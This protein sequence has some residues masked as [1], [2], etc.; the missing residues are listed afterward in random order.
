MTYFTNSGLLVS[1]ASLVDGKLYASVD[2]DRCSGLGVFNDP[3]YMRY[4]A[5]GKAGGCFK[6]VGSGKQ[7]VRVYSEKQYKS[8]SRAKAKRAEKIAAQNEFAR[9]ARVV[10]YEA[11]EKTRE[12]RAEKI[13]KERAPLVAKLAPLAVSL[14]DGKGGFC[15]SIAED[16]EK[17]YFPKGRGLTIVCEILAKKEGRKNSRKYDIEYDRIAKILN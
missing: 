13:R 6:C 12:E 5:G 3:R 9:L 8:I 14:S 10:E 11:E 1:S 16:M 7:S 15:D 2:C 4:T 17:G